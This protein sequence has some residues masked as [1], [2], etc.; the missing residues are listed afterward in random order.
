MVW[1]LGSG[2]HRRLVEGRLRR[3][4]VVHLALRARRYDGYARGFAERH[5][6]C[7]VVNLGCGLD[8]RFW[9]VDDGAMR[10]YA[11]DSPEMAGLKRALLGEG[12]SERSTA[13]SQTEGVKGQ[14]TIPKA[15][16]DR[17]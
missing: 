2:I 13:T 9:R 17:L 14:I 15:V 11:L 7:C 6:G 4:L 8:T 5:P 10:F 3:D 16:R 12:L 1:A